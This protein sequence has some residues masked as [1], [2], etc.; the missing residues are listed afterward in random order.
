MKY[1]L[2]MWYQLIKALIPTASIII[3]S[4]ANCSE[5]KPDLKYIVQQRYKES[6]VNLCF[7]K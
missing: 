4:L 7:Y 6:Q 2:N 3:S 5:Q 1:P